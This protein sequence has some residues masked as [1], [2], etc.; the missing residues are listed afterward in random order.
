MLIFFKWW[1]YV[2]ADWSFKLRRIWVQ[3]ELMVY[4]LVTLSSLLLLLGMI[5]S[6]GDTKSREKLVPTM[7]S[8]DTALLQTLLR[9]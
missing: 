1:A 8:E 4:F 9:I 5:H 2:I 6:P 7:S 3:V